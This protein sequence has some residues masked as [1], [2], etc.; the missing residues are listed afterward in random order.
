MSSGSTTCTKLLA[1]NRY[2]LDLAMTRS[3]SILQAITRSMLA[4]EMML[5]Q[6]HLE[7]D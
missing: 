7:S 1:C 5:F 6:L 3:F 2:S 4:T